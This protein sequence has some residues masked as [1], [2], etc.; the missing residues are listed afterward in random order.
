MDEW[1]TTN[2]NP[3]AGNMTND[4]NHSYTYDAEG[5]ITAVDGGAT[6][7]YTYNAL[8]QRVRTVANGTTTVFVLN[9]SGQRVSEWNGTTNTQL[10]GHYYWGSKPVA[11][12]TTANDGGAA[13]HFQHQDWLGT[14]RVRTAYNGT[15]EGSYTN[16]PFG[17]GQTTSGANTDANQYAQLDQDNESG[18][19]HAQFRQYQPAQGRWLSP[20]PYDG[21]YD[22]SNPQ[23][24]NRYVYALN[25]PLSYVDPSGQDVMVCTEDGSTCTIMTDQQYQ[26][27]QGVSDSQSGGLN[28]PPFCDLVNYG[29]GYVTNSSGVVGSISYI[30]T[31][32]SGCGGN[33]ISNPNQPSNAPNNG[34][35]QTPV[36]G[37]WTYGNWCGAGGSGTPTNPTDS[38]C[39]RHDMCYYQNGLTPGSNFGGYNPAVQSCNQMLCDQVRAR[40]DTI[41]N[42]ATSRAW[43]SRTSRGVSPAYLPGDESELQAGTDINIYFTYVVAPGGN[44]CR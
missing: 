13:T 20:D 14:E 27:A 22:G 1:E 24:M 30:P 35:G 12:Y 26:A 42:Q 36:H 40:R 34:F 25:N 19:E 32:S 8:N 7:T 29:G 16:L 21:S 10:K 18:T 43:P 4:G 11:Y 38:A 15:V 31:G 9:A 2:L 41:L 28:G 39:K 37:A 44:S 23:S 3:A 33:S 17:D 6:A 5:N